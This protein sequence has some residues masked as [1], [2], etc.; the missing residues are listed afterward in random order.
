MA[1]KK[2]NN[3]LSPDLSSQ[4]VEYIQKTGLNRGESRHFNASGKLGFKTIKGGILLREIIKQ[5]MSFPEL[6]EFLKDYAVD[7]SFFLVKSSK[8]PATPW[9]QDRPFWLDK[10]DAPASLI[11]LWFALD[12][13]DENIGAILLP[14]SDSVDLLSEFNNDGLKLYIHNQETNVG[15]LE[16]NFSYLVKD[17]RADKKCESATP[18]IVKQGDVIAFD[19]YQLHASCGMSGEKSRYA[20]KIVLGH[21]NK[22]AVD[23]LPVTNFSDSSQTE[24][25]AKI[26]LKVMTRKVRAGFKYVT[27]KMTKNRN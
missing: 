21:R 8:G 3:V 27:N 13:I 7:H 16:G 26:V 6:R 15:A 1:W 18:V 19:S 9:H 14:P 11:T 17:S 4:L 2:M 25:V 22:L 20:F 24:Y 10:E 5:V 12:E 23:S